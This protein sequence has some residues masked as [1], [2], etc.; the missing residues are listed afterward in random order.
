MK[1]RT[2]ILATMIATMTALAGCGKKSPEAKLADELQDAFSEAG[3]TKE[4]ETGINPQ[5][6]RDGYSYENE[7]LTIYTDEGYSNFQND[8]FGHFHEVT[9]IRITGQVDYIGRLGVYS[10]LEKV[11]I[12]SNPEWIYKQTF[13]N[14][15]KIETLVLPDS[16]KYID[17][18]AFYQCTS[19]K[20]INMPKSLVFIKRSAFYGCSALENVEFPD[21]L[22]S[23]GEAAFAH[24]TSLTKVRIPK[25]AFVDQDAFVECRS[26]T[27]LILEDGVSNINSSYP[28]LGAAGSF[29]GLAIPSLTIPGSVENIGDYAF[30]GCPVLQ[31]VVIKDGVKKIGKNAFVSCSSLTSITIP[32]SVE[33][34]YENPFYGCPEGLTIY[35]VAGSAAETCAN[36]YGHRFVAK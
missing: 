19:L 18:E 27:E 6:L 12:E 13:S 1:K 30:S 10:N 17:E 26:I 5:Y 36:T 4:E 33:S 22:T 29:C 31:N 14:C 35:G 3:K 20:K 16:V 7:L 9:E 8:Y 32:A 24:C 11:I 28:V 2:L 15:N 34:I 25:N 21:S 23:I